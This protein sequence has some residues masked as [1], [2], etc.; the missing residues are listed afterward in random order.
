MM[1]SDYVDSVYDGPSGLNQELCNAQNRYLQAQNIYA[2]KVYCEQL[3]KSEAWKKQNPM[4]T[5]DTATVKELNS[6][7]AKWMKAIEEVE[8]KMVEPKMGDFLPQGVI[9][10]KH[11]TVWQNY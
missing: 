5:S 3:D 9:K 7:K 10:V 6:W 4:P 2:N 1:D 8:T 11:S